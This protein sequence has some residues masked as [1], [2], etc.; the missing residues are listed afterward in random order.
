MKQIIFLFSLFALLNCITEINQDVE[1]SF[2]IVNDKYDIS[3]E[4]GIIPV[5]GTP[6]HNIFDAEDLEE[7]TNFTISI[8][9]DSG[10][11]YPL[12]CRL[13]KGD[14]TS[15]Y[16]FCNF[17]ESLKANKE[18]INKDIEQTFQYDN[19]NIKVKFH[20]S[21]TELNKLDTNI[22]FLYS[23]SKTINVKESDPK[24]Y[25]EFKCDSYHNE[26][27]LIRT[28]EQEMIPRIVELENC[29]I[30]GKNLKC[31]IQKVNLD[32]IA[33]ANNKFVVLYVTDLKGQTDFKLV[34]EITVNYPTVT[35][36]E[37][38]FNL[39]DVVENPVYYNSFITFKT[40]ANNVPKLR[41][42][43]FTLY[44]SSTFSVECFFIKHDDNN[45]L[46]LTCYVPQEMQFT[47][48]E[49]KGFTKS[50][51]HYKYNFKLL[52]GRLVLN[53]VLYTKLILIL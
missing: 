43:F 52:P 4:K 49:I 10:N 12:N 50:D 35:K 27:L 11:E 6:S 30:N 17:Q 18:V 24:V 28:N 37:I 2:N 15:I 7:H 26:L 13:W 14:G 45:P 39:G 34:S 8:K 42:A 3:K 29:N 31:E 23:T 5:K 41:S 16:S 53:I 33:N 19:N 36:E 51:K 44:F 32:V 22:P 21:N 1:I 46:Y 38:S 48:G 9:A 25:F 47:I 20:F 40:T